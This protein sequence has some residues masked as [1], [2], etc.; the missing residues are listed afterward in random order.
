MG[1]A[2]SL[3][4]M[5]FSA[6]AEDGDR[7]NSPSPHPGASGW[8]CTPSYDLDNSQSLGTINAFTEFE[9]PEAMRASFST[10]STKAATPSQAAD[11]PLDIR[12]P[13]SDVSPVQ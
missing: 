9:S 12:R 1:W 13:V 4:A 11:T 10:N 6:G 2:S 8:A 5:A 7:S 3:Q